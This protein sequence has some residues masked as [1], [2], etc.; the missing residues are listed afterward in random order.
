MVDSILQHNQVEWLALFYSIKVC[1]SRLQCFYCSQLS[2]LSSGSYHYQLT[3]DTGFPVVHVTFALLID[4]MP[5]LTAKANLTSHFAKTETEFY[6]L[7]NF[8]E[9]LYDKHIKYV[10]S[11]DS[12]FSSKKKSA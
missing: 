1:I 12:F 7:N 5:K 4:S 11:I 6:P 2:L 10:C 9:V 3:T 8:Y